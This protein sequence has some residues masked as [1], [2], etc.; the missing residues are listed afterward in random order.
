MKVFFKSLFLSNLV[1]FITIFLVVM[2]VLAFVF[3]VLFGISQMLFFV[4]IL[5]LLVDG[6]ML[7]RNKK[8]VFA[9]R[10]APDRLSNGDENPISIYLEN[11]Y[12]FPVQLQII[13]EIPFQFQ[14]R[15]LLFQAALKV[16]ETQILEYSL[17]PTKR[18]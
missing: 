11:H 4:F 2:F 14:E 18:G 10:E 8:G 17:R 13:D 5:M 12:D 6:I 3:P 15:D 1:F 9:R 7:Y 16:A